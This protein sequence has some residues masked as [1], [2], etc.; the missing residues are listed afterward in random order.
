MAMDR[1][2][3]IASAAAGTA[4][5][6]VG[7][8][9]AVASEAADAWWLPEK[10]DYET[11]VLVV[12]LGGAGLSAAIAANKAGV[13]VMGI[14]VAP[15]ELRG[16]NTAVCGGGFVE[17]I[18]LEQY[19]EVLFRFTLGTGDRE[20]CADLAK[21]LQG[22]CDW[23]DELGIEYMNT[24][25]T[26][27]NFFPDAFYE[28]P[29][30]MNNSMKGVGAIGIEHHA[31][32]D[33]DGAQ[34]IGGKYFYGAFADIYDSLE[35]PTLYE[36]RARELVQDPRTKEIL[37]VRAEMPDG[38]VYI[39]A[40]KGVIL[41]CGG[42]EANDEMSQ[43]Y[44]KACMHMTVAGSP[45][46]RGDGVLMSQ[47]AGA[48]LWHM[49]C[50]E[51]NGIGVR[52]QPDDP[53]NGWV[54]T[55]TNWQK[56]DK[57][58]MV[59]RYGYRFYNENRRMGHTR[60]FPALEF[61]G[62][63]DSGDTI[64]DY[65]GV[66]AYVIFD[67]TRFDEGKGIF[68]GGGNGLAM[69]WFGQKGIYEWSEDNSA[70]LASGIIKKGETL[71]ELGEALGLVSVEQ[72]VKTVERYNSFV[73]AGVDEDFGRNPEH[74]VKIETGPF[75]GIE[76]YPNY[77]NTQGGP[78]HSATTGRVVDNYEAEI[79]RLYAA[80]ELGSGYGI[81]YQGSGNTTEAVMVGKHAAED[82]AAL[83]DWDA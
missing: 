63:A 53:L 21:G 23:M 34:L 8:A 72:F 36:C 83:P 73:D 3:F 32:A 38:D 60:T 69:G 29:D 70:E 33:E 1:R 71:E 56:E 42:F 65:G 46:N 76:V 47:L 81:L 30:N 45:F 5:L 75:Y 39:K 79:P 22:I 9:S 17:P 67:Q 59:N 68:D 28:D 37:G 18:D 7:A 31:L 10:W 12:G 61:Q 4:A 15:F 54:S 24:G 52:L 48:K 51:W 27:F 78:K 2:S 66:P 62:Y 82:C 50:A 44:M 49:D 80:G 25:R 64:N 6:S 19:T 35:I 13:D 26:S 77:L 16:G 57:V 14:E 58:I 11:G 55:S 40:R 41:A 43:N 74:M 20:Q